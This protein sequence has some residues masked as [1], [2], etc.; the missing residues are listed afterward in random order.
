MFAL[1]T[2]LEKFT[3][4]TGNVIVEMKLLPYLEKLCLEEKNLAHATCLEKK[5]IMPVG[6]DAEN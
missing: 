3:M 5:K 2:R 6:Q 1:L 4:I